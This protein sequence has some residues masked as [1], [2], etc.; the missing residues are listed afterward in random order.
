MVLLK[1]IQLGAKTCNN[2]TPL[3]QM[4]H[5]NMNRLEAVR[6]IALLERAIEHINLLSMLG[7]DSLID[8]PGDDEEVDKQNGDDNPTSVVCNI[9]EF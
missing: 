9:G 2:A 7:A 5:H 6:S 3:Q 1:I 4:Q 8:S